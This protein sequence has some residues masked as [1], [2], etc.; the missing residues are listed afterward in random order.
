MIRRIAL[1]ATLL[2][3]AGCNVLPPAAPAPRLHDFGASDVPA[4]GRA[5]P[6]VVNSVEAPSWLAGSAIL[7]RDLKQSSTELQRY[8]HNQWAAPP[9]EMLQAGL[10]ARLAARN[11]SGD[12]PD[13]RY[14]LQIRLLRF[15]QTL[16]G[17]ASRARLQA[18]AELWDRDAH[19]L[20]ARRLFRA[21]RPVDPDIQG[22]VE[23]LS[24][25]ARQVQTAILDWSA[26][27]LPSPAEEE[28][29]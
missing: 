9:S 18:E 5:L 13:P 15:E 28:S 19:R 7:Y 29:E 3:L 10:E 12:Q 8:A 17:E 16:N 24:E 20:I 2:I 27:E 25:A 21:S 1:A 4:Q 23:G 26:S 11:T 22:A 14:A 6:L